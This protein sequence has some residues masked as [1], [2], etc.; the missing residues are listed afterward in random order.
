MRPRCN[1]VR[2]VVRERCR[3][4]SAILAGWI[5]SGFGFGEG[6]P[7]DTAD[8]PKALSMRERADSARTYQIDIRLNVSGKLQAAIGEGKA[9][10]LDLKV[11]GRFRY[12][13]RLLDGAGPGPESLRSVRHYEHAQADVIV[14]QRKTTSRLRAAHRLVVAHGRHEGILLYCVNDHFSP[15]EVMLLQVPADSLAVTSLLPEKNVAVGE[16]W[17]PPEWLLATLTGIEAVKKTQ[18]VCRL[19]QIERDVA[20]IAFEGKIEGAIYGALST[21]SVVGIA[22]FD[23]SHR[24]LR[25]VRLTQKEKRMIG[26]VAPGMD[27][28]AEVVL[29]RAP[30]SS[31]PPLDDAN[32]RRI[33]LDP[34]AEA[35]WLRERFFGDV[36]CTFDRQ[37]HVFH[38][39]ADA[40]VLRL[41]DN[42]TLLS[43]CNLSPVPRMPAGQHTPKT[44]FVADIQASLGDKLK[45]IVTDAEIPTRDG[46]YVYRVAVTGQANKLD[47]QWIYYLCAAPNGRQVSLVFAVETKHLKRFGDRD[48][49][50]VERLR[51]VR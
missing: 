1:P 51:F 11:D 4:L 23:T 39:T 48:R 44:K 41:V 50:F 29:T 10:S 12:R 47:M 31:A 16:T 15:D 3:W 21:I 33:P 19:Q 38:R 26:S 7:A 28:T 46:R 37:W 9:A 8:P 45:E 25:R 6:T 32:V 18:L 40:A 13:E 49:Q 22:E 14:N 27:V 17:S 24:Y 43:Q 36:V 42:G 2:P 30:A 35:L 34:P 20:T 5:L